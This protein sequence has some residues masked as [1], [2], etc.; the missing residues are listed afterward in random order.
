MASRGGWPRGRAQKSSQCLRPLA[1]DQVA[2]HMQRRVHQPVTAASSSGTD[3]N[4][5]D[6]GVRTPRLGLPANRK[7]LYG[8]C[9]SCNMKVPN[10]GL[11]VDGKRRWCSG[12]AKAHVGAVDLMKR[13]KCELCQV[14][15]PN[16]GLQSEGKRRWCAGCAKAHVGAENLISKCEDCGSKRASLGLEV[17]GSVHRLRSLARR[18]APPPRRRPG[19]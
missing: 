2:L 4:L 1:P 6:C 16:F 18:R 15:Q 19:P 5:E 12:C 14:K 8:K 17:E 7:R 9:E 13:K 10:F 11:V 3:K